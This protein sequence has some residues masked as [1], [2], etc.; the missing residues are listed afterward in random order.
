MIT[1]E[2]ATTEDIKTIQTIA[3]ETWA[4]AFR[5]ILSGSQIKYM[6]AMMYSSDSIAKQ[7]TEQNHVFFLA[8]EGIQ[9]VGYLSVEANYG[10]QNKTKIHKIY[11]LPS[12]QGKGIGKL[13]IGKATQVAKEHQ[14]QLLSLNVNRNNVAVKFYETVGFVI[15]G[16]EN[17]DIGSGF[18]MEDYI[19]D[20]QLV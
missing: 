11:I 2:K 20:K 5:E 19:M 9:P 1:I 3:K 4:V 18:L 6:L 15:V 10:G 7:M 16:Q 8:T 12:A 13:L 14:N 17:I